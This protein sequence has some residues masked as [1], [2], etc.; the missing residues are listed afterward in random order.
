[1]SKLFNALRQSGLGLGA[2]EAE[3]GISNAPNAAISSVQDAE[4]APLQSILSTVRLVKVELSDRAVFLLENGPGSVPEEYR[5]IRTK[6][7]QELPAPA[8]VMVS[9]PT[10]GDGKTITSLNLAGVFA[11]KRE[12]NVL[13]V[14]G[15]LL[16]GSVSE[17]LGIPRSPGLVDVL[18][19]NHRLED[20]LVRIEEVPNLYVLPAG[21]AE[22]NRTELLDSPRWKM[23]CDTFRREFPFTIVD[24]P[25]VGLVADY[26]LLQASADR[27]MLV[28]R[29]DHTERGACMN[30]LSLIP[31][32]KF[33]GVVL[34]AADPSTLSQRYGYYSYGYNR[35]RT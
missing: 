1:M 35:P 15:D 13:I 29:P 7:T 26:D 11:M 10:P 18:L 22:D 9:S 17:K 3:D 30:A 28:V 21:K 33:I 24:A 32:D 5:I 19:G 31:K 14:D 8:I 34:N 25:P 4:G 27:V 16:R 2:P 23:I 20:A 6:L 12:T